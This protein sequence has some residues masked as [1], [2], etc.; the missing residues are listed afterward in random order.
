MA[1]PGY[2]DIFGAIQG[3]QLGEAQI[4]EA[5][6]LAGYRQ[7]QTQQLKQQMATEQ[8]AQQQALALEQFMAKQRAGAPAAGG[9]PAPVATMGAMGGGAAPAPTTMAAPTAAIPG[10]V[11]PGNIDL[12]TRPVVK[13]KDGSI[14]TV[15]SMSIGVDGKEVLIPTVSDDG[16]IMSDKEAI[17]N[18]RKTGKNLGVF[19]TPQ[20]ATQYAEQLHN[21][22]AQTYGAPAAMSAMGGGGQPAFVDQATQLMNGLGNQASSMLNMANQLENSGLPGAAAKAA[23]MRKEA[24]PLVE[25]MFTAGNQYAQRLSAEVTQAKGVSDLLDGLSS[26]LTPD[27]TGRISQKQVED[28]RRRLVALVPDATAARNIANLP[29]ED[30]VSLVRDQARGSKDAYLKRKEA[31]ETFKATQAGLKEQADVTEARAIQAEVERMNRQLKAG[32][33][34]VTA[35][36]VKEM[37]KKLGDI[38]AERTAMGAAGDLTTP[39]QVEAFT[40]MVNKNAIKSGKV[41]AGEVTSV[42]NQVVPE[43]RTK[44]NTAASIQQVQGSLDAVKKANEISNFVK[45]NK[46]I[47]GGWGE[48]LKK[49]DKWGVSTGEAVPG[50]QLS[51]AVGNQLLGKL[52]LDFANAYARAERGGANPIATVAELKAAIST[53]GESGMSPQATE[54]VF[55]EIAKR[56][57]NTVANRFDIEFLP[58]VTVTSQAEYDK[59]KPGQEF[60]WQGQTGF[61]GE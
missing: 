56:K 59:L 5:Q 40:S 9:A 3:Q 41:S 7:M 13:N 43:A 21:Q 60:T 16:R 1:N 25:H 18:Y 38:G 23:A 53:F 19:D 54:T 29:N 58:P 33:P 49:M 61:K 47:T 6:Q 50:D 46:I 37:Q 4:A 55:K 39:E 14:S 26:S 31:A 27:K 28:V 34:R 48:V 35:T 44:L 42:M 30:L 52:V 17:A 20:A 12:S 57:K 51:S 22:Q 15:R 45:Q 2:A 10:L 24:A 36:Q 8:Q 32:D 11:Q